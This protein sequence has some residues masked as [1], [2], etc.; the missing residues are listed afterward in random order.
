MSDHDQYIQEEDLNKER[1]RLK[2]RIKRLTKELLKL[3]I[4]NY[5]NSADDNKEVAALKE[6]INQVDD[7]LKTLKNYL[8]DLGPDSYDDIEG[9][10]LFKED[11]IFLEKNDLTLA[12]FNKALIVFDLLREKSN[13]NGFLIAWAATSSEYTLFKVLL[14]GEKVIA[15][16]DNGAFS[17]EDMRALDPLLNPDDGS[18]FETLKLTTDSI[19]AALNKQYLYS[20]TAECLGVYFDNENLSGCIVTPY[21]KKVLTRPIKNYNSLAARLKKLDLLP[22]L[23][24]PAEDKQAVKDIANKL[25]LEDLKS[26]SSL[27]SFIRREAKERGLTNE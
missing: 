15:Q 11:L 25:S 2:R 5:C 3:Q 1:K 23:K 6:H 21:I 9:V 4:D 8:L 27:I 20:L 7:E 16:Y 10:Q 18:F 17:F 14:T 26:V 13:A 12:A 19:I 24:N 22:E